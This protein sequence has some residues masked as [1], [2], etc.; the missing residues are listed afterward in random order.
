[1]YVKF[2]ALTDLTWPFVGPELLCCFPLRLLYK[3]KKY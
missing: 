2:T 3:C 1:M